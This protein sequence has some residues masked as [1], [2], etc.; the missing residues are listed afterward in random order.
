MRTLHDLL[1]DIDRELAAADTIPTDAPAAVAAF[2]RELLTR[3]TRT[4]TTPSGLPFHVVPANAIRRELSR[5][6]TAT[7]PSTGREERNGRACHIGCR[8]IDCDDRPF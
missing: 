2:L 6:T 7:Q 5:L 8:H 1:A 3:H 4:L